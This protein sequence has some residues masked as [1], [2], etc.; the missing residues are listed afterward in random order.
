MHKYMYAQMLIL[1][2]E[3]CVHAEKK[4]YRLYKQ[5]FTYKITLYAHTLLHI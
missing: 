4:S 2:Y 5:P 3:V 1:R